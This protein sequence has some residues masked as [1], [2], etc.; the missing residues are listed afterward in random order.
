[1]SKYTLKDLRDL[2][3]YGKGH[4]K[5]DLNITEE[6][7]VKSVFQAVKNLNG[8]EDL[9]TEEVLKIVNKMRGKI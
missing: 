1:M 6:E 7:M 8:N 9:T 5:V 4:R 3:R 2:N